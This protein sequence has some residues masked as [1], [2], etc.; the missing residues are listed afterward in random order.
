MADAG[1]DVL[2]RVVNKGRALQAESRTA[3]AVNQIIDGLR[4]D[5]APGLFCELREFNF[6]AGALSG[7]PPVAKKDENALQVQLKQRKYEMRKAAA[8]RGGNRANLETVDIQPVEFTRIFDTASTLLFKALVGCETLDSISIVKRKA[9]GAI[10]SGLA[11]LR[12]DFTK[13][14]MTDL[15]WKDAEHIIEETGTFIYREVTVRYRPQK[16]DGTLG[17]IIPMTWKMKTETT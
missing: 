8:R 4:A 5:F 7:T 12:L 2:M 10:N 16:A 17:P 1:I 14:L 9:A 6:S 11:Y 15:E 3:F 13:V